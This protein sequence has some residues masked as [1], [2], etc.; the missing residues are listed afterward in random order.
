MFVDACSIICPS[1][2]LKYIQMNFCEWMANLLRVFDKFPYS[3][4]T[5]NIPKKLNFNWCLMCPKSWNSDDDSNSGAKRETSNKTIFLSKKFSVVW[6][7]FAKPAGIEI[8][9]K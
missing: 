2:I 4:T 3:S 5:K 7:F 8:L 1:K 9:W 6:L